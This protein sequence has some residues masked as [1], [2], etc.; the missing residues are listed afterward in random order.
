MK[1]LVNAINSFGKDMGYPVERLMSL[2]DEGPV[3][4]TDKYGFKRL[5]VGYN[6]FM[7]QFYYL[8]APLGYSS[9]LGV[10]THIG[11]LGFTETYQKEFSEFRYFGVSQRPLNWFEK[12]YLR[13]FKGFNKIPKQFVNV[14]TNIYQKITIA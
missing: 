1:E 4:W 12:L 9:D 10:L 11:H 5:V 13:I 7:E 8:S 14:K 2:V 6:P 3:M